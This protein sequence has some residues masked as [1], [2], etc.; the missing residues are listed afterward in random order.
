MYLWLWKVY[1]SSGLTALKTSRE[2]MT[3]SFIFEGLRSKCHE[4]GWWHHSLGGLFLVGT[5]SASRHSVGL[6]QEVLKPCELMLI[7]NLI[8]FNANLR[9]NTLTCKLMDYP[10][11]LSMAYHRPEAEQNL[12]RARVCWEPCST[13]PWQSLK[14]FE[15]KKSLPRENF[16]K[17]LQIGLI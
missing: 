7:Y 16:Q 12:E 6:S 8:Q 9:V 17:T 14:P 15:F 10:I 5:E 3:S 1:A 2:N 4:I 13:Y 11:N